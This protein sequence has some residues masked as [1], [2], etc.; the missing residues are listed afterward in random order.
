MLT[1]P[2]GQTLLSPNIFLTLP[3]SIT[4]S[5]NPTPFLNMR[6]MRHVAMVF[7]AE[8]NSVRGYLDGELFDEVVLSV[9]GLVG[10]LDCPLRESGYVGFGHRGPSWRGTTMDI[11]DFR[12]Y[13]RRALTGDAIR[14]VA[15]GDAEVP[16]ECNSRNEGYDGVFRDLR[17]HSCECSG[18]IRTHS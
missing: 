1:L 12:M 3:A 10:A 15:A 9:P 7:D 11:Q 6:R 13:A 16:R 18:A 8:S 17:G 14:R 5:A 4:E 2:S